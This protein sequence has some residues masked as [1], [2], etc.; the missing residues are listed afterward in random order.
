MFV[1]VSTLLF[2][3][4]GSQA[5]DGF[6]PRPSGSYTSWVPRNPGFD[7]WRLQQNLDPVDRD[8]ESRKSISCGILLFPPT[9]DIGGASPLS[10]LSSCP[11]LQDV[12][13]GMSSRPSCTSALNDP[14]R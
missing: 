3:Q 13:S 10:S 7:P 11:L 12:L 5:L 1:Y 14:R 9:G 6:T 2:A 8:S 4:V